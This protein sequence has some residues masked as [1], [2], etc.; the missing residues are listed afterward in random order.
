MFFFSFEQICGNIMRTIC[1][2]LLFVFCARTSF[3][4]D[5]AVF[6]TAQISDESLDKAEVVSRIKS[7]LTQTSHVMQ[8][9]N[10]QYLQQPS[11]GSSVNLLNGQNQLKLFGS[12][13][14]MLTAATDRTFPTG[15][16]MF[17]LPP[18]PFGY[19]TNTFD[20]HARQTS[21]GAIYSGPEVDGWNPGAFFLGFIQNDNLSSDAYGFLPY[22]A[23]GELKNDEWRIAGGLQSDVFNPR[24]PT[25][26]H[27]TKLF[28]SGNTGSFRGQLRAEYASLFVNEAA[29]IQT[30]VALSEP[31]STIVVNNVRL[32]EDN[33]WP[34]VELRQ[35][36]GFGAIET[37]T[38]NRKQRMIELGLSGFVGQLR[39]SRLISAPGDPEIPNREVINCWG[40]GADLR[41][42]LTNSLGFAGEV[43]TGQGLGEYNGGILQSFNSATFGAIRATGGWGEVYYYFNDQFHVHTGYGIDKPLDRDL[44]TLSIRENQTFFTN[45]IYDA[46]KNVQLSFQVMYLQ[47]DYLTL[48][49]ASGMVYMSQLLVSF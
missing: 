16:P 4:Q 12:F 18:S 14:T 3:A 8:H 44:G 42:E 6:D 36:F 35:A 26:M 24:S 40:A 25:V 9:Y 38:G 5:Q 15:I 7:E 39:T 43:F 31:V 49:D 17:L 1:T 19:D 22:N 28:S 47:T 33:G 41:V 21:I 10:S 45:W 27:L 48:T 29:W 30:Q 32:Q 20:I 23:Y 37:F 11:Q 34:N 13:S 2:I 46:S